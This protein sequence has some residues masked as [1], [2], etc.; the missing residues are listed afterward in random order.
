MA[1]WMKPFISL[2]MALAMVSIFLIV[3]LQSTLFK[4]YFESNTFQEKLSNYKTSLAYFELDSMTKE[5]AIKDINITNEQIENYRTENG[6]L[7][8]QILSIRDEYVARI[9]EAEDM[10]ATSLS[11]KLK[12]ERDAK[13]KEVTRIFED[14]NYVKEKLIQQQKKEITLYYEK[15]DKYR[16][17]LKKQYP[18]FSYDLENVDTGETF[19]NATEEKN[20]LFKIAFRSTEYGAFYDIKS[21]EDLSYVSGF[22]DLQE[23]NGFMMTDIPVYTGQIFINQDATGVAKL[24]KEKDKYEIVQYAF[25]IFFGI[26]GL[27]FIIACILLIKKRHMYRVYQ[28]PAE[29]Q[30]LAAIAFFI[31]A[32]G[33]SIEIANN[34]NNYLNYQGYTS[35]FEMLV[36]CILIGLVIWVLMDVTIKFILSVFYAF[37]DKKK[38]WETSATKWVIHIFKNGLLKSPIFIKV[39]LYLIIIFLAGF[40]FMVMISNFNSGFIVLFYVSLYILF[41][42]PTTIYFYK[43]IGDLNKV[44][45]TTERIVER[46]SDEKIELTRYSDF[47][48]LAELINQMQVGVETSQQQQYKSERLKTELITNVSHDLRTPLTSIITYTELLKKEN[49]ST[50]ERLQYIDVVDKKS[51]R[52]KTLIDDLFEVSK[53]SSGN[54]ELHKQDVDLAQL[55]QQAIGEHETDIEQSG[56]RFQV[57]IPDHAVTT[58]IDGQR[59]WRVIDNL[60]GNAIK[61]SMDGTRVFVTL[62]D[63]DK[64]TVLTVKNIS[65]Y[66]ISEDVEEL[67]ERFK[68][69]DASRHTEG[70][71]LGLAI[72]QSIVDLHEGRMEITIDGDLFKVTVTQPKNV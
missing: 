66:E 58:H 7:S 69:A 51:Q 45:T 59:Y 42:V 40:G 61:Y 23:T 62:E 18:Y 1:K 33:L 17:L 54:I 22:E 19:K 26:S 32:M 72:A 67:Y 46:G 39:T 24:L 25:Y 60:V 34:A 21:L 6:T 29:I 52:L 13:I 12:K 47:K 11:D 70:S 36:M 5:Q 35:I 71:G 14:R 3:I 38:L 10:E 41:V 55:V 37:A 28:A 4:S 44:I 65:K 50:E 63:N 27:F 57:Q 43:Q 56:L 68:R 64:Q 20:P 31:I 48:E 53:M 30:M 16:E 49:L 15:R 9:Q 8:D 2:S